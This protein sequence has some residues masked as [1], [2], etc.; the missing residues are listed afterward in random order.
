MA[1]LLEDVEAAMITFEAR[2]LE[3]VWSFENQ[4]PWNWALAT[5][6]DNFY[7]AIPGM[8]AAVEDLSFRPQLVKIAENYR[9]AWFEKD[10][11]VDEHDY[12]S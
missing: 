11:R 2:Y 6:E 12:S 5:F 9:R 10:G 1:R 4:I 3:S 8:A 7:V